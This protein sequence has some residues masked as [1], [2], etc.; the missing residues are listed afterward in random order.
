MAEVEQ[1][2]LAGLQFRTS[3]LKEVAD[4]GRKKKRHFSVERQLKTSDLLTQRDDG[5]TFHIVTKDGQKYNIPKT[6]AKNAGKDSGEDAGKETG[7]EA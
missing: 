7:K 6:P 2:H 3:V 1:K 5:D 4:D